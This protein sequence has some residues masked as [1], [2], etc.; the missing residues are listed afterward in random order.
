MKRLSNQKVG[1]YSASSSAT[2]DAFITVMRAA[3]KGH[4]DYTIAVSDFKKAVVDNRLPLLVFEASGMKKILQ[5]LFV[6]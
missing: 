6:L 2:L 1:L 5:Q 4:V 3:E